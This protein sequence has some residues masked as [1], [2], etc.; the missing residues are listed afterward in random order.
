MLDSL[1][2]EYQGHLCITSKIESIANLIQ[3][4]YNLSFWVCHG[5]QYSNIEFLG[6]E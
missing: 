5:K 1:R 3:L 2:K 4:I 6:Q